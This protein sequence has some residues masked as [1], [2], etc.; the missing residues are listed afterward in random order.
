MNGFT[1]FKEYDDTHKVVDYTATFNTS[2]KLEYN[3]L[4]D[5]RYLDLQETVLKFAVE[6]PEYM[7]P[8]A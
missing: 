2:S 1:R 5:K 8:G 6:I 4:P 3:I 7:I